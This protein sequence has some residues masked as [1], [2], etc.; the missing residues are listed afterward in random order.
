MGVSGLVPWRGTPARRTATAPAVRAP[1]T[2]TRR[3]FGAARVTPN[4]SQTTP[5]ARGP[6][7]FAVAFI[8][9][10]RDIGR[11]KRERKA[12]HAA[13]FEAEYQRRA[14]MSLPSPKPPAIAPNTNPKEL[15]A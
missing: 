4:P 10:Q 2:P 11:R 8:D 9:T 14:R 1:R 6:L 15:T 5:L 7:G 12:L 3:D 13:R